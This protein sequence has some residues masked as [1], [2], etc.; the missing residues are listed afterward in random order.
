M[1]ASLPQCEQVADPLISAI[2]SS[3]LLENEICR[4]KCQEGSYIMTVLK[5]RF[6]DA[7]GEKHIKNI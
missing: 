4:V 1:S 3:R 7:N 2:L 5:S 6:N